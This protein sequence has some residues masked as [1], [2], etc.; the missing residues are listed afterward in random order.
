MIWLALMAGGIG[1]LFGLCLFRV[2]LIV[3]ASAILIPLCIGIAPVVHWTP[4]ITSIGV[5]VLATALQGGY[6]VG[7]GVASAWPRVKGAERTSAEI[8]RPPRV[9]RMQGNVSTRV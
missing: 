1:F 9:A 2:Q 8:R 3:A 6:L 7:A 4:L 5:F